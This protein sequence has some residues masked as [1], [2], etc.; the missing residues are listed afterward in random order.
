MHLTPRLEHPHTFWCL[1]RHP[2]ASRD[3][4]IEFQDKKLRKLIAHAYTNVT[5]YR[6]LFH[7][8]GL[9]PEE[10]QSVKD[11]RLI[12]VTS[13]DDLRMR[14]FAEVLAKDANPCKLVSLKTSGSSG[15]PF[16]V[17]RSQF[18]EH[19]LNMFRIRARAQIGVRIFD[20]IAQVIEPPLGGRKQGLPGRLRQ[21]LGFYRNYQVNGLQGSEK[22]I[23]EL[24]DLKPDVI[25]GYPSS[26]G[27]AAFFIAGTPVPGIRPRL[28]ITGGEVLHPGMRGCI[29]KAFCAPVFDMYGAHE[30]N[31]L[32]WECPNKEIYHVCDDNVILEI[33]RDGNPVAVG[34]TGEVVATALHSYIMPFIRYQ[35]G[36]IATKGPDTC[37]CGQPFS[38]LA[39]IQ[40]R[41]VD[42]FRLSGNR[43][44]H[45]YEITGPLIDHEG[46]WVFQ[47][48][49]IEESEQRIILKIAPLRKPQKEKL[50][51][52]KRL[53]EERLGPGVEFTI[54]LVEGFKQEP[55]KKF[56]P[57]ICLLNRN[58][59]N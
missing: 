49:L 52:L 7:R 32:A 4:L 35:T 59:V 16:T 40:G 57:Y 29:E 24:E 18:E 2:T 34:E 11:L 1:W 47:H 12:P 10:I 43:H 13:K 55:G 33:L 8:A 31:L 19:L 37:R 41:T 21:A 6:E 38:T 58:P 22:I 30:F 48:Q 44:V 45:P 25:I 9:K 5:H 26:L 27:L 28:I 23:R 42:Y 20:R 3:E 53:G 54:E 39:G 15:K 36:D 17:R 50:E 14:P 46:D 56:H 51:R